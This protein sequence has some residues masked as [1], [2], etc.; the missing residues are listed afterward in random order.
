LHH[1]RRVR[2]LTRPRGRTKRSHP[3]GEWR[4]LGCRA[5]CMCRR[6]GTCDEHA[7]SA[8]RDLH[9]WQASGQI[10]MHDG[11]A[12]CTHWTGVICTR[13]LGSRALDM[14]VRMGVAPGMLAARCSRPQGR[15]WVVSTR[16]VGDASRERLAWAAETSAGDGATTGEETP[17]V[18]ILHA[19]V[20][21]G[22]RRCAGDQVEAGATDGRRNKQW[23]GA[24]CRSGRRTFTEPTSCCARPLRSSAPVRIPAVCLPSAS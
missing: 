24:P 3:A 14:E 15:A 2:L 5:A 7:G 22:D 21:T 16:C 11:V 1:T 10:C 12:G 17:P 9:E 23:G 13:R 19:A 6:R 8:W 18:A 4:H 20:H